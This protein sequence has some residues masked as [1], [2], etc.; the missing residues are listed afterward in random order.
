MSH[1]NAGLRLQG[2]VYIRR[3]NTTTEQPTIGPLPAEYVGATA[4]ANRESVL[5]P[6][7]ASRGAVL[8]SVTD[9]QEPSGKL[10][11]LSIPRKVLAMLFLGTVDPHA[12]RLGDR[13]DYAFVGGE[14]GHR[15]IR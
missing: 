1:E 13:I 10:T 8:H 7:R 3:T 5:D 9:P 4:N 2:E 6:R 12:D 11:L 14:F 15:S